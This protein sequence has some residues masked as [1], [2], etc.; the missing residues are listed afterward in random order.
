MYP[1][2]NVT[3]NFQVVKFSGITAY[4]NGWIDGSEYCYG[5]QL[6]YLSIFGD[7]EQ[8]KAIVAGFIAGREIE[9]KGIED[10]YG[11][12]YVRHPRNMT[13]K[14]IKL[15][16]GI[17]IVC[18]CPELMDLNSNYPTKVVVGT[19][20]D[21]CRKTIFQLL[22][23]HR[24]TPLLPQW[25]ELILDEMRFNWQSCYGLQY[26]CLAKLLTEDELEEF[27]GKHV[28]TLAKLSTQ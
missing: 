4:C 2:E 22:Q 13:F 3:P 14:S 10:S 6:C 27:V 12:E 25:E 9:I 19:S 15:E 23:K 20:H 7:A 21:E 11:R 28:R 5:K 17:H 1:I 16:T 26:A 8:S 18:Y 24:T